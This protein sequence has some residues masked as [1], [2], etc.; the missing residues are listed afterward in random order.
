MCV[1][2]V[3]ASL[4]LSLGASTP[5]R[6]A[7]I[8]AS[9]LRAR[10][11]IS[12]SPEFAGARSFGERTLAL[13]AVL[14][15][16]A[17]LDDAGIDAGLRSVFAGAAA[18]TAEDYGG[19]YHAG[20]LL[21][22]LEELGEKSRVYSHP[23][24][25]VQLARRLLDLQLPSGG[26]GDV[27]RTEFAAL[28]LDA[29]ERM[30]VA[31][32]NEVWR[33]IVEYLD[34]CRSASGG[35]GYRP[36]DAPTG[37]MTVGGLIGLHCAGAEPA[38][39]AEGMDW[40]RARFRTDENPGTAVS[41]AFSGGSG[42]RYYYLAGIAALYRASDSPLAAEW[43][44]QAQEALI[45]EQQSNGSWMGDA[46]DCPSAFAT[47]VLAEA[48]RALGMAR[49]REGVVIGVYGSSG[50]SMPAGSE[51]VLSLSFARWT[52]MHGGVTYVPVDLDADDLHSYG[53][54]ILLCGS[55]NELSR[56][57]IRA[58][59]EYVHGG[60][61]VLVEGHVGSYGATAVATAK[62][63][64]AAAAVR[65]ASAPSAADARSRLDFVP[66]SEIPSL[67]A[68]ATPRTAA[69]LSEVL[70]CRDPRIRVIAS[71]GGLFSLVGSP[72]LGVRSATARAAVGVL[73]HAVTR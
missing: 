57:E 50:E 40:L 62:R 35:W 9:L 65:S 32:S 1:G 55:E 28:G 63:L 43:L 6:L 5:G 59:A 27:S 2:A 53:A 72:G 15:A 14:R 61:T 21:L 46:S 71:P 19:T 25:P 4:A 47:I 69:R 23:D 70:I 26:W 48:R 24:L 12:A 60:G 34:E 66:A 42:H 10:A 52:D 54:V 8:D 56:D 39:M 17:S 41:T 38:T 22:L 45:E 73:V 3:A 16:G 49:S 29:A 20:V 30:G 51:C 67:V 31:L 33:R 64:A 7:E 37:S 36:Q 13:L 11:Y 58:L 68:D 18:A 44:R